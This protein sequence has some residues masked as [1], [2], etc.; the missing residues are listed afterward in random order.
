ML[1]SYFRNDRRV[2]GIWQ[3]SIQDCFDDFRQ[4]FLDVLPYDNFRSSLIFLNLY[5][6]RVPFTK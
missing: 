4:E 3:Y 1:E 5:Q 6:L 2:D